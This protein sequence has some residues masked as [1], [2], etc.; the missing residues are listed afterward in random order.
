MKK[1]VIAAAL[2]ALL[3]LSAQL[4][5]AQ[6]KTAT[7]KGTVKDLEGKVVPGVAVV[8]TNTETGISWSGTSDERGRFLLLTLSPGKYDIKV[9]KEQYKP[10][11]YEGIVL[12]VGQEMV[13][14]MTI[15]VGAFEETMIIRGE[16]PLIEPTKSTVS[17]MITEEFIKSIP[18]KDRDYHDLALLV[19][20]VVNNNKWGMGTGQSVNGM[21]GFSNTYILDGV[22]NDD[23]YVGWTVSFIG[24]DTIQEFDVMTHMATAEFGQATGGI[25]NI[26]TRSGTNEYHGS[27]STFFRDERFMTKPFFADEKAP[28]SR[29][30][31]SGGI[32][33]PIARDKSHFY[34]NYEGHDN[35]TFAVITA[36]L[37]FGETLPNGS[38]FH[39]WFGKVDY[40]LGERSFLTFRTNGSKWQQVN[41]GVG[42]WNMKEYGYD[43]NESTQSY[44]GTFSSWWGDDKL[45]EFRVSYS[46]LHWW[47]TPYSLTEAKWTPLGNYG[48][49]AWAPWDENST[50]LQFIYNLSYILSDH[51]MKF[52]INYART[53][54]YGFHTNW[55]RGKW[56]FS[57]NKPFDPN[58]LST[59]PWLYRQSIN[60]SINF[61]IP[62][63]SYALFVQDQWNITENMT[64]NLGLRWDY[65]DFWEKMVGAGTVTGEPIK[66]DSD[67]IQPR[68][69]LTWR[70][71][72]D[73]NTT[74]RAGYG[75]FYDQVPNNELGFIY[76]NTVQVIGFLWVEGWSEF[77]TIPIYPNTPKPEDF[78]VPG[79]DS[80]GDFLDA[81]LHFPH[82]DQM[83][84]GVSHQISAA[85][86]LHMD[87]T[88]SKAKD[89]WTISS[90]NP[91]DP[92][93]GK[94]PYD[95]DATMWTQ[96]AICE[97]E[98][99]G[100]LTRLEHRFPRGQIT[101]AYTL[102]SSYDNLNGDPNSSVVY[103]AFNPMD[104]WGP[105]TN[106]TPHRLV[107]SGYVVLPWEFTASG[108]LTYHAASPYS[109]ITPD[110]NNGDELRWEIPPGYSRGDQIGDDYY[111]LDL[112]IGKAFTL[113]RYRLE[114]FFEGYNLTNTLN[115]SSW[116]ARIDFGN[117]GE[118]VGAHAMREFQV[119]FRLDF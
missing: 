117:F 56:N 6:Q 103:N 45:N 55:S 64:L 44:M 66:P 89:L 17:T 50:K 70:P 1:P 85:T 91:P 49:Y 119:G 74:V 41:A 30:V 94:R 25:V 109:A 23:A 88:Y 32:G 46:K 33:G 72:K 84:I 47:S 59:Y 81:E 97:S 116:S 92:V 65:E 34:F 39:S 40:L 69:G 105:G 80:P 51:M 108:L 26:A 13:F 101:V 71:F 61:D 54:V 38:T 86:A 100:L 37:E 22:S 18:T 58:D 52:G 111:S 62:Q 12:H 4:L 2:I 48:G 75:R 99:K 19:P 20:G 16:A 73:L 10:K 3:V 118:P 104:G 27:V 110:D 42:G 28:F 43:G 21:R 35:D 68:I 79:G 77:G 14:P 67:N 90:A 36:P 29:I 8:A 113:D 57:S 96:S 15:E 95:Y 7:L 107:L 24:Q 114:L 60:T 112:R 106:H 9:T 102:S 78:L 53:G 115:Y 83:V 93:T 31:F 5:F 82:L 76:L 63:N 11:V 87:F 98:Y